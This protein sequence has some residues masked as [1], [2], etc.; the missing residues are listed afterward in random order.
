MEAD[1]REFSEPFRHTVRFVVR[2][3]VG[4]TV[5]YIVRQTKVRHTV[6]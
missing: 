1:S 5:K 3:V 2:N 6:Q 4:H